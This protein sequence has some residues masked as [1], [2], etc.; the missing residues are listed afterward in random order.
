MASS[1][2]HFGFA[3]NGIRYWMPH[4]LMGTADALAAITSKPD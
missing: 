2:W 4:V 1:P 3:K